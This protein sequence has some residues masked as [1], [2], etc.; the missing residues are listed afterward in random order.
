MTIADIGHAP[1]DRY[2]LSARRGSPDSVRMGFGDLAS[3]IESISSSPI[4]MVLSNP[5]QPDNP[6]EA[7]NAAFCTL[8]GY[9]EREIIG[10]NCRFLAGPDT[11]KAA[12][13]ALRE[14]IHNQRPVLTEILN[15]RQDGTSFRN[16]VTVAPIYD[17]NGDLA[18]FIGS[19]LDLGPVANGLSERRL[20]AATLVGNLTPRERQVLQAMA[21]GLLN[22][23]IAWR[24][25][26]VVKTVESHRASLLQR[27]G[28]AT[29]AEAIRIAVE[30]GL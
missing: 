27:L 30:A 1:N 5:R 18:L 20:N 11:E 17:G 25:K 7:A 10:R 8:T 6:L 4:P 28:V 29:S 24:L 3:V 19:Q 14:A 15:Y 13:R 12:Q 9:S 2:N 23:Q 22:K 16:K 21:Q 26:I